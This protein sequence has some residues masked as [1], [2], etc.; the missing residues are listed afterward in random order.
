MHMFARAVLLLGIY[1]REL[2]KDIWK[3]LTM[4]MLIKT[5]YI[6]EKIKTQIFNKLNKCYISI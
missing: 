2:R 3:A 1:P 4:A 5:N 6:I